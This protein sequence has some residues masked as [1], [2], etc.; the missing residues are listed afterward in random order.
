MAQVADEKKPKVRH[1]DTVKVGRLAIHFYE[2]QGR[3]FWQLVRDDGRGELKLSSGNG[4]DV[5]RIREVLRDE[6][7]LA[8]KESPK[9]RTWWDAVT[10]PIARLLG[11]GKDEPGSG[12]AE[13]KVARKAAHYCIVKLTELTADGG[14]GAVVTSFTDKAE[15]MRFRDRNFDVALYPHPLESEPKKGT[16]V[17]ITFAEMDKLSLRG[18]GKDF[19][20]QVERLEWKAEQAKQKHFSFGT[21]NDKTEP[22]KHGEWVHFTPGRDHLDRP[23]ERLV[24]PLGP[25]EPGQGLH[26][27]PV[28]Y[29]IG[30]RPG[31]GRIAALP[32]TTA[33]A[34]RV[35]R[36]LNQRRESIA[37][38]RSESAWRG[39]GSGPTLRGIADFERRGATAE[40]PASKAM[41]DSPNFK[42]NR[43]VSGNFT[44]DVIQRIG[45][46][47]KPEMTVLISHRYQDRDGVLRSDGA[48]FSFH[49][50]MAHPE[51]VLS[52]KDRG[53]PQERAP[54]IEGEA[55]EPERSHEPEGPEREQPPWMLEE[56]REPERS[57][58]PEGPRYK[59]DLPT[60]NP[61]PPANGV[62]GNRHWIA[63]V[64]YGTEPPKE[65]HFAF[66]TQ[67]KSHV[68]E[69]MIRPASEDAKLAEPGDRPHY[70][71]GEVV[72]KN[73]IRIV[74]AA[75]DL[76]YAVRQEA[77]RERKALALEQDKQRAAP[78]RPKPRVTMADIEAI[79]AMP[80][81]LVEP[82][83]EPTPPPQNGH[84]QDNG[85][86]M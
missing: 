18:E 76:D 30:S 9:E 29:E 7:V 72:A 43:H 56:A 68:S 74:G 39:L 15:A 8:K 40:E 2:S 75:K 24:S 12:A 78:F 71:L 61:D 25:Y 6:G 38:D 42:A 44:A 81:D 59:L 32:G 21:W 33:G 20:H 60:L 52:L 54:S 26:S 57:H 28:V 70:V 84:H 65:G 22:P 51:S 45:E 49:D 23:I 31:I 46:D 63:G 10:A 47:G 19:E 73:V 13:P 83:P 50:L 27:Q 77:D 85:I 37:N 1:L 48:S 11:R 64:W 4:T 3:E 79:L 16:R 36:E 62:Q 82:T 53:R 67:G 86:G 5:T 35:T 58:E 41:V 34:E 14:V 66:F 17:E 55:R 69:R 80:R